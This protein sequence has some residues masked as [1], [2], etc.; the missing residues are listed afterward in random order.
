MGL[1]LHCSVFNVRG[2]ELDWLLGESLEFKFIHSAYRQLH[3]LESFVT[4]RNVAQS[5]YSCPLADYH[6]LHTIVLT[7][8]WQCDF[9]QAVF[10]KIVNAILLLL[11]FLNSALDSKEV[12]LQGCDINFFWVSSDTGGQE[13]NVLGWSLV[14]NF[15]FSL[16]LEFKESNRLPELSVPISV[17]L[18]VQPVIILLS[19]EVWENIFGNIEPTKLI[20]SK[21]KPCLNGINLL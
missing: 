14:V 11:E 10:F 1:C 5:V 7:F 2:W 4:L 6:V 19:L 18:R 8:H 20:G 13:E 17:L 3:M 15:N 21:D 16:T 9:T 12:N